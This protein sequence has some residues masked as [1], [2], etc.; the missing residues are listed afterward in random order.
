V[1]DCQVLSPGHPALD[2][3]EVSDGCRSRSLARRDP[4]PR[5]RAWAV[6][7]LPPRPGGLRWLVLWS[8]GGGWEQAPGG[9][10]LRRAPCTLHHAANAKCRSRP[11]RKGHPLMARHVVSCTIW[12]AS[13]G[14][15]SGSAES[16]PPQVPA[17][18]MVWLRI[19]GHGPAIPT[20]MPTVLEHDLPDPSGRE[21]EGEG[22]SGEPLTLAIPAHDLRITHPV[23]RPPGVCSSFCRSS[24]G[25]RIHLP[26]ASVV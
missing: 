9:E 21:I 26:F 22:E 7:R 2:R 6:P 17:K 24:W 4:L 13:S 5:S 23:L 3:R 14:E 25:H 8:A 16:R 20:L 15:T 18:L 10:L 11:K 19:G 12:A 1:R